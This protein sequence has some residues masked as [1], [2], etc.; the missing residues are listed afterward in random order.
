LY[1]WE[2]VISEDKKEECLTLWY[3]QVMTDKKGKTDS[4]SVTHDCKIEKGKIVLLHEKAQY[5]PAKK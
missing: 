1:Y 4:V 2:S 3:K 5:Y